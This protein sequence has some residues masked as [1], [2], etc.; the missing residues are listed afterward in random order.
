VDETRRPSVA[1]AA[2]FAAHAVVAGTIG[3]WV[4]ALKAGARIEIAFPA[5]VALMVGVSFPLLRWLPAVGPPAEDVR[6]DA[7]RREATAEATAG[8]VVALCLIASASFMTE[9][10]AAEWSALYLREGIGAAASV[11]GL[12][13]VAFSAGMTLSRLAGDRLRGRF[14]AP[15]L[16]RAGTLFGAAALGASVLTRDTVLTIAA[17]AVLGLG[18]GPVV[19][20]AFIAAARSATAPGRSALS[21]VVTAGYLG[22]VLGPIAMG[23]TASLIGLRLAFLIPAGLCFAAAAASPALRDGSVP[24]AP[25]ARRLPSSETR[26]RLLP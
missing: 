10:I 8:R 11:A 9:G 2:T 15:D 21:I 1:V 22:T 14:A 6:S 19:P 17:L 4:P 23:W 26:P 20:Y 3:P 16:A 5:V 7:P 12:G 13:V 24:G 18:I 25:R